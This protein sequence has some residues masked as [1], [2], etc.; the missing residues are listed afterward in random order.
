MAALSITAGCWLQGHRGETAVNCSPAAALD[1]LFVFFAR[2]RRWTC[3]SMRPVVSNQPLGLDDPA[4]F[5]SDGPRGSSA[6]IFPP[7]ISKS[8]WASRP[9]HRVHYQGALDQHQFS[10]PIKSNNYGPCVP[11]RVGHLPG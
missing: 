11:P 9:W 6:A 3:M 10:P 8:L 2:L 7:S 1:G 5:G 4:A